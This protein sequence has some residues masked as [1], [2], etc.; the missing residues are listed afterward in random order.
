MPHAAG[1]RPNPKKNMGPY[2]GADYNLTL[3][4]LTFTMANPMPESTLSPSQ[5]L[6]IGPLLFPG[7][8]LACSMSNNMS[9]HLIICMDLNLTVVIKEKSTEYFLLFVPRRHK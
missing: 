6:W 7:R 1:L 2:A 4:P 8:S 9:P 3:C 5:G